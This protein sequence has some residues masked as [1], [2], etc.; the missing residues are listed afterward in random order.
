MDEAHSIGALGPNGGGVVDF[1]SDQGITSDDVELLM[2][3]YTK[4]FGS[5]GG[6]IAGSKKALLPIRLM[7]EGAVWT[8]SFSPP[9]CVM[10]IAALRAIREECTTEFGRKHGRIARLRRNSRYFRGKLVET[11]MV[12]MGDDESPV[13]PT[14]LYSAS[15]LAHVS[16]LCLE[17]GIAVVVVGFPATPLLM[18]RIRF[19]LSATLTIAQL[20]EVLEAINLISDKCALRFNRYWI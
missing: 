1:F 5:V 13:I 11:G 3:T 16:R 17:H 7:S 18:G 19:C 12:V 14:M 9:C 2:G 4:S 15:R 20:D 8:S 10:A 6:Y